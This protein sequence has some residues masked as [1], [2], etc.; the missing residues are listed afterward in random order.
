MKRRC[1]RIGA[2]SLIWI[3]AALAAALAAPLAGGATAPAEAGETAEKAAIIRPTTA[4][5]AL[6]DLNAYA[7]KVVYVDFWASWCKP[8]KDSMPWL[9]AMQ[10]KY[11]EQGLVIVGVNLD[12][13]PAAV[14]KFLEETPVSF[15]IVRDPLGI[16]AREYKVQGMPSSY[17]HD[18]Q[19][20]LRK[21]TLGFSE[22]EAA[23]MEA[24]IQTLL[25]QSPAP[26][27]P[28]TDIRSASEI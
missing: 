12:R 10:E 18:R 2:N 4:G 17:I 7:G 27:A 5:S 23:E 14:D 21:S 24:L 26:G 16:L 1:P 20:A 3:V 28:A 15:P 25:R 9:N 13:V 19:G 22:H 11:G 8:C 6:L